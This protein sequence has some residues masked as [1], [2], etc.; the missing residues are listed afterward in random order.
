MSR[1]S[2]HRVWLLLASLTVAALMWACSSDSPAPGSGG[3][4]ASD[5]MTQ[6]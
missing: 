1:L 5:A 6:G 3:E 4:G 2:D